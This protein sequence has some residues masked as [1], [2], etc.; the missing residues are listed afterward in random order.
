MKAKNKA[1]DHEKGLK[2]KRFSKKSI[3]YAIL[4]IYAL[5]NVYPILWMIL[6]S[7]KS[8][9]EFAESPFAFPA[10]WL[11]ENYVTAWETA[12][13]DTY[14]LNSIIVSLVAVV[15]TVFA[16]ALASYF[17]ARFSFKLNKMMYAFFVFGM[18]IPIH[19]TLVPMFL[20]MKNLGLLN[21]HT[22][23][24][25]P[26]IAFNLPI[27]IFI[28]VSFMKAFPKDIEESAIMDGCGVFRIF[29]SIILPMTKPALATVVIL[30]FINNW[31]EF[32]FALVL[33]N[34]EALKTLPLGLANFAGQY[35]TNYGAQMAGLTMAII[36]TIAIYMLL[37]EHLVKGM[38]AGAV[39]G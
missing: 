15:V 19:A 38:T 21:T 11:I 5:I 1:T 23:L 2:A 3:L 29:W 14:F 6:N 12:R 36:P 13:L 32:S 34:E 37:E 27:T 10:E 17:L 22:G 39:K 26:Y 8:N 20:L 33:I 18:L 24:I 4:I 35:T 9:T 28:L 7:F 30:N 25:L 16:G 31:N